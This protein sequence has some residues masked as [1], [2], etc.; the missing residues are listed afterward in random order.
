MS[1][2]DDFLEALVPF[3]DVV[4]IHPLS[5]DEV[6]I[7]ERILGCPLPGYYREFLLK[8][9][10]KQDVVQ[11]LHNQVSDFDNLDNLLPENRGRYFFRF[12]DNHA[13][14]YWLLRID[15]PSDTTIYEYDQH[16][17]H[18]I[19]STHKT[20]GQLLGEAI[21][22]LKLNKSRLVE[23]YRKAWRVQFA[24]DAPQAQDVIEALGIAFDC[25]LVADPGDLLLT[26]QGVSRTEG[27]IMIDNEIVAIRM[28]D[29]LDW[30][31]P[32]YYFSWEEPVEDMMQ[33][34]KI[35]RIAAALL[36][37]G[38]DITVIDYGIGLRN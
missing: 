14:D 22:H 18:Q 25:A 29:A 33:N 16:N 24:I 36:A 5:L 11:G 26:D 3:R 1:F 20:F 30:G 12:G 2:V 34:S 35:K 4:V 13:D 21:E 38:L 31:A 37:G 27:R 17:T 15:D 6:I 28:Q 23:N 9:G 10:L 7:I 8:V 32:S 19:V